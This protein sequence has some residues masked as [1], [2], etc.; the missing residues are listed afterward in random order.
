MSNSSATGGYLTPTSS[1]PL[2]GDLTLEQFIHN[3][4]AGISGYDNDLVRP[5]WQISPPKQPNIDVNWIAYGIQGY[6]PDVN[7]YI[8]SNADD[9][10]TLIRQQ[11]LAVQCAFYGPNAMENSMLILDGFQIQQNLEAMRIANMG[12]VGFTPPIRGPDLV[13]ERWID[14]YELGIILTRQVQRVY[15]VLAFVGVEGIIKTVL[16]DVEHSQ[17]F[18]AGEIE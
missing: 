13:N 10:S 4:I 12:Y 2:P 18:S 17:N 6:G 7:A 3:V 9:T 16:Q 11:S 5:K 15:P 8:W 14:R 1:T